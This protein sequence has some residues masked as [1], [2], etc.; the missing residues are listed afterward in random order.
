LG[1]GSRLMDYIIDVAKDMRLERIFGYVISNNYKML[2]LCKKKSF[3]MET[4]E[5]GETVKASLALS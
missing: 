1:L 2:E 4:L 3:K 5:D